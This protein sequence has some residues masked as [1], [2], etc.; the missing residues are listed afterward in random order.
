VRRH[1]AV[2][3]LCLVRS[4]ALNRFIGPISVVLGTTAPSGFNARSQ[5]VRDTHF[6]TWLSVCPPPNRRS[7]RCLTSKR[8]LHQDLPGN[9]TSDGLDVMEPRRR[10]MVN[11]RMIGIHGPTPTGLAEIVSGFPVFH[12]TVMRVYDSPGK[13]DRDTRARGRVQR[14]VTLR[15]TK[16]PPRGEA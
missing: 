13:N 6:A 16:K 1:S 8:R 11:E 5:D 7:C 2:A 14:T 3:S 9:R 10:A 15:Q 4:T 12:A